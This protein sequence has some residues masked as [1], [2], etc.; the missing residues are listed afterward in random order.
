MG[1]GEAGIALQHPWVD[2][3]L[4]GGC[5]AGPCPAVRTASVRSSLASPS[6]RLPQ[7]L[8]LCL[9]ILALAQDMGDSLLS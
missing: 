9:D 6:P 7:R 1:L 4:R 5:G 3:C 2:A 8:G